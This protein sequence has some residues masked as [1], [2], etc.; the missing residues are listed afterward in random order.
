MTDEATLHIDVLDINQ[1]VPTFEKTLYL[2][3]I[4]EFPNTKWGDVLTK[5]EASDED[6]VS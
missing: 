5:V 3:E 6:Y 1:H 2:V 4:N